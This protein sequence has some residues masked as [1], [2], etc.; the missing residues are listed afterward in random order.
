M[1]HF[2]SY[3]VKRACNSYFKIL[4]IQDIEE[5]DELLRGNYSLLNQLLE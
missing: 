2:D 1:V 5:N 3:H 4:R